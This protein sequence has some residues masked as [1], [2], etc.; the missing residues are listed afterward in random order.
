MSDQSHPAL[1]KAI[2]AVKAS[3]GRVKVLHAD[4]VNKKITMDE[5]VEALKLYQQ[6]VKKAK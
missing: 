6:E 1:E 4:L 3:K 2:K 5:V